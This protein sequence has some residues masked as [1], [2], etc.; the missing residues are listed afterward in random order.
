MRN[1]SAIVPGSFRST[2]LPPL[3]LLFTLLLLLSPHEGAAQTGISSIASDNISTTTSSLTEVTAVGTFGGGP[4]TINFGQGNNRRIL[5]FDVSATTY[6]VQF[7]ADRIELR[8][9]DN[10]AVDYPRQLAWYERSDPDGDNGDDVIDLAPSEIAYTRGSA[11]DPSTMQQILLNRTIDRGTDNVFVNDGGVTNPNNIERIDFIFDNGIGVASGDDPA[12]AGFLVG[13]RGGNDDFGIAAITALDGNG[14]PSAYGSL[15]SVSSQWGC[16]TLGFTTVVL[17]DDGGDS[18]YHPS[19]EVTGQD[20]CGVYVSLQD[21]GVLAGETF[22]GYS[23]FGG[24]VNTTDHTLTDPSTFPTSTSNSDGGLDLIAGGDIFSSGTT[25]LP[26]EL[27][28]FDA[29]AEGTAAVL[30]W[31][32]ASETNNAGFEVQQQAVRA[33]TPPTA[34]QVLDW[35]E[36]HGTTAEAQTYRYR[37]EHLSPGTHRFRLR[38]IDYDGTFEF[39]PTIE[40]TVAVPDAYVVAPA[41]PN[42]AS[43]T[44]T[45]SVGV[46]QTQ[47]VRVELFN[48]LGQRTDVLAQEVISAGQVQPLSVDVE[49]L[50]AGTYFVRIT[51]DGF[52]TTQPLVITR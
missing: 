5:S 44:T 45:L 38:Q 33:A 50:P 43:T 22:F 9:V 1:S 12:T 31:A 20:I 47:S 30:R 15:V 8:R 52:Q 6:S 11:S 4:Y 34:W 41:H 42:P 25:V 46:Q 23:L 2:V 17:R 48:A 28:R 24:D 3:L 27:V 32:T 51:G 49:H 40:V 21:L 36:G 14:D 16:T 7:L 35:V 37:A 26:V 19:A 10:T 29:V 13:D 39:S 18:E